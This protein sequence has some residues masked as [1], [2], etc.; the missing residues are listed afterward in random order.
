MGL[1]K[2]FQIQTLC[3]WPK[4]HLG[5]ALFCEKQEGYSHSG[6]LDQKRNNNGSCFPA[7]TESSKALAPAVCTM[8]G[9][10]MLGFSFPI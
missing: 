3:Q 4:V 10:P 9:T 1:P 8:L 2:K 5:G 6:L 7:W